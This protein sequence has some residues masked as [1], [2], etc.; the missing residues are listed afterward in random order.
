MTALA[1]TQPT[2]NER[3]LA[4][5]AHALSFVEGGILAPL[6]LY[7]FRDEAAK[8]MG[9]DAAVLDSRFVAFHSLQS[10][11]FGLLN[12]GLFVVIGLPTCGWGLFAL[13]PLYLIF[14]IIACVRANDG[15][16]YRLPLAGDWA[17]RRHPPPPGR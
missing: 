6:L 2:R 8:V 14:E 12:L 17:A 3:M 7:V 10:L 4:L 13:V 15:E 11:Y 5:A 9:Q 16:W 1:E